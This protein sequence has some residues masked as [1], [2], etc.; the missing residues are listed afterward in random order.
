MFKKKPKIDVEMTIA[1]DSDQAM[2]FLWAGIKYYITKKPFRTFVFISLL[3]GGIVYTLVDV[4]MN[5]T[6]QKARIEAH[7]KK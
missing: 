1:E 4:Y 3:A 7:V 6:I 2:N 5:I